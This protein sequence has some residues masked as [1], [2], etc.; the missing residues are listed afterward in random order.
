MNSLFIFLKY[1]LACFALIALTACNGGGGGDSK[2]AP[3]KENN[4]TTQI[5]HRPIAH[6]GVDQTVTPG[7]LVTLDGR[8]SQD[9]DGDNILFEWRQISGTS[10]PLSSE[11]DD[12]PS[13]IAPNINTTLTFQLVVDDGKLLS[14]GDT[15]TITIIN[16]PTPAPEPSPAPSPAQPAPA[17]P[18][19]E[20]SEAVSPPQ[21]EEQ[22][23]PETDHSAGNG[24]SNGDE[25]PTEAETPQE[26]NTQDDPVTDD[27][28]LT[29]DTSTEETNTEEAAEEPTTEEPT[30]EENINEE[31]DD[32]TEETDNS[33]PEEEIANITPNAIAGND[34]TVPGFTLV[35]LDGSQ[36]HDPEGESLSYTWQQITGPAVTLNNASIVSPNFDAPNIN[37]SLVFSLVVN[38]GELNSAASEVTI[39]IEQINTAPVAHAGDNQTVSGFSLVTLQASQSSDPEGDSLTYNWQQVTGTSVT[40]DQPDSMSPSFIAPNVN[41]TLTFSLSVDDGEFTSNTALVNISIQAINQAPQADAGSDQ[42]VTGYSEVSLSGLAS[43]DPEG[44][45]LSY[46][47]TQISGAG[48]TLNNHLSATPSF[49]A[50]NI[51]DTLTFSLIVNDGELSSAPDTVA[52]NIQ[53]VNT[54][55]TAHAGVDRYVGSHSIV[56]LNGSNSHDVDGDDLSFRWTQVSGPAVILNNAH[57]IQPVFIADT[58]GILIFSLIVNDGVSDS[59]ADTVSVMVGPIPATNIKVNGT[60]ITWGA[61]FPS[62]NNPTCTGE[63]IDQQDCFSGR[64]ITHNDDSDGRAGFTFTKVDEQGIELDGSATD[65]QCV[66]DNVTGLMWEIKTG[67]NDIIGDEGINDADDRHTWYNSDPDSNG[68]GSGAL[69]SQAASCHAYDSEDPQSYC[70]NQAFVARMNDVAW[71]GYADWRLPTRK[72]LLSIIDYGNARP[73][74]DTDYFPETGRF[75]WSST[76]LALGNSSA[77]GVNFDYG[78]SFSISKQNARQIRL[79][80]GGYE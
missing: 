17:P 74:I 13:F 36:S 41:D 34:R 58:D 15:V 5:N 19:T 55:P 48:V 3:A 26:E 66:Q 40:L 38:D 79:V 54:P 12:T 57:S 18:E 56:A 30:T 80:R 37:T 6:A 2:A 76:P 22:Q 78:N 53:K 1:C 69:N 14:L 33:I 51:N 29:E 62:G 39:N 67:G 25:T 44:E 7:Q 42:T 8:A 50:P 52:M 45:A 59:A 60:G 64:E 65:W 71:C 73:M 49:T 31:A 43:F 46:T 47:W 75:I 63:A 72:E 61:N 70:N 68:G 20:E 21:T 16:P 11:N 24:D 27:E 9:P 35:I 4:I 77:W 28:P 23:D 10:T 32:S